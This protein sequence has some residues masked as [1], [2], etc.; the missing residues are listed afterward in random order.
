[1][2]LTDVISQLTDDLGRSL[3]GFAPEIILVAVIVLMLL[4]RSVAVRST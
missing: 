1:M 3:R 2:M 4:W